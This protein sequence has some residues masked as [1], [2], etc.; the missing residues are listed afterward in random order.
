MRVYT[1]LI[2]VMIFLASCSNTKKD[3]VASLKEEV[4]ALHDEVMPKMG[5][6]HKTQKR[7]L[8]L[9]DSTEVSDSV[10]AKEYRKL[11]NAIELANESMMDWMRNFEPNYVG[12]EKEVATYLETKKKSIAEVKGRMLES[13]EAGKKVLE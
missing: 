7:L 11:A 5:E 10:A 13:L 9:A 6:L 12:D 2:V 3:T 1:A 4:M 8:S